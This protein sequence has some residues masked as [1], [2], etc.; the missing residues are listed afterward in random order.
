MEVARNSVGRLSHRVVI[1]ANI[2][3]SRLHDST[4]LTQSVLI[5]FERD[6]QVHVLIFAICGVIRIA[7]GFS[8]HFSLFPQKQHEIK[9]GEANVDHQ[10]SIIMSNVNAGH[11]IDTKGAGVI[12]GGG[13]LRNANNGHEMAPLNTRAR[14]DGHGVK[15]VLSPP[16]RRSI[17]S[18]NG[19]A[20]GGDDPNR[21]AWSGKMQFFLSI[22]GYSVGLGNIWRFPYLCQQV[23]IIVALLMKWC[24]F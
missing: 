9:S 19:G 14:G 23:I 24:N 18:L 8:W 15:I 7:N 2:V 3:I 16:Q 4:E 17:C 1:Y 11:T 20:P 5:R 12:V 10:K 21:A 13:V 6:E 22:I